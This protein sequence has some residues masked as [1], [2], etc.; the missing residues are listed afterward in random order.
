VVSVDYRLAPEHKFPA[1]AE[2]AYAA[3]QWA[4][5]EAGQINGDPARVA[6][7]GDSAGGNLAAVTALLARDRGGPSL[8]YQLL[9]YPVCDV[10]SFET[11]SHRRYSIAGLLTREEMIWFKDHYCRHEKDASDPCVSP[12]L[13]PDLSGLPPALVVTAELDVLRDEGEAYAARLTQAGVRA[14]CV[15]CQGMGHGFLFL[16]GA[17]D[18]AGQALNETAKT[19]RE[20]LAG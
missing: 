5:K 7:G 15:R 1:A 12:L 9:I 3:A 19:L 4:V 20:A 10:S 2:D 8:A 14:E 16:V 6:V 13:A 17:V 11:K 18:R